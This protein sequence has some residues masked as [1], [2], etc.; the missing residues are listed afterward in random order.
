MITGYS[1][2]YAV[3]ILWET[4]FFFL[5]GLFLIELPL[6]NKWHLKIANKWGIYDF[7]WRWMIGRCLDVSLSTSHGNLLSEYPKTE[8]KWD[9]NESNWVKD[10]AVRFLWVRLSFR[11]EFQKWFLRGEIWELW[12]KAAGPIAVLHW[13]HFYWR[14]MERK[15]TGISLAV[16]ALLN[17]FNIRVNIT[18]E[19]NH[20]LH[21]QNARP[22]K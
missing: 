1:M 11:Y 9:R 2:Y 5:F 4:W 22:T 15:D 18:E 8:M 7:G 19:W 13:S 10:P 21:W 14:E 6:E 12:T 20:P 16:T 17:C 3:M